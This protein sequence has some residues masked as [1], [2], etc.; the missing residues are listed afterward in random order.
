MLTGCR[1]TYVG[2]VMA[3]ELDA[4]PDLDYAARTGELAMTIYSIGG[5]SAFGVPLTDC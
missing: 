3:Y 5:C 2:Q 4:E 1:T